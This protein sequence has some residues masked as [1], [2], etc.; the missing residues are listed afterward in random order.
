VA[1]TLRLRG[2]ANDDWE[3]VAAF[4][5]V[6]GRALLA[7]GDVGDN[8]G[9][10]RRVEVDVVA[11]PARVR[12]TSGAGAAPLL[13]LLLT[14]P[15]GPTDAEAL[16]V[17]PTRGRMFVVTKGLFGGRVYMVPADAWDGTAPRR[18]TVRS[19]RL[20]RIGSVPLGLVTDGTVV[21][22]GAVLLRTYT[23][24]AAFAPFP[25]EPGDGDLLPT[26]SSTLPLQRQGEGLALAPG[27]GAVLLASEGADEP[28]LRVELT[29]A[30]RAALTASGTPG[31]GA[32]QA[33]ASPSASPPRS[34]AAVGT[35]S[36][37][38]STTPAPTPTSA[39]AATP[40]SAAGRAPAAGGNSLPWG[41]L[42][43]AGAVVAAVA[44]AS[45][46]RR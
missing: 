34:P 35:A 25:V 19:A 29:P 2:T 40:P 33:T 10:R 46:S 20:V 45:G 43:V 12:E 24:L 32:P 28:I 23:Q 18:A 22:G 30:V 39:T 41:A 7:V 14:Y 21:P 9:Q 13:R 44:V 36:P 17:D 27:G 3:A 38:T 8:R 16:L 11:E 31:A 37:G 42:V 6:G 4:R 26:A 5:D 1:G 15:D